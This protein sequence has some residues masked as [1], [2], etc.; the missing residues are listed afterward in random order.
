MEMQIPAMVD[1]PGQVRTDWNALLSSESTKQ[2]TH[3]S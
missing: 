1:V 3:C 2:K